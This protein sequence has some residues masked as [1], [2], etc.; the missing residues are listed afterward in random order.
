LPNSLKTRWTGSGLPIFGLMVLLLVLLAACAPAPAPTEVLQ[1][2]PTSPAAEATSQP[3]SPTLPPAPTA[4]P[5]TETLPAEA[6]ETPIVEA[7]ETVLRL[8]LIGDYGLAGEPAAQVAALVK[9]WQPD[10]ILT[11]GDNNYPVGAAET[12]DENIG[13]YYHE[14]IGSYQGA[15][16]AG[17][18]QNRFY[19]ALGNHDLDTD[20][21]QPYYDYFTLPGNERY[22]DLE[23]GP[24]QFFI[25][26]SDSREPDG[27]G[28]SSTQAAWLQTGLFASPAPWKLVISHLPPYSSG[29]H[30]S[31]D[32]IQWPFA[33]WGASAVLSGHDHV[34]ERLEV[35]GIPYFINGLGGGA[36][37]AF[38]EI[39]PES[40]VRYRAGYGAMLVEADRQ[41]ILFRFITVAGE[42]ID[43]FS[44]GSPQFQALQVLPPA[45]PPQN[46]ASLPDPSAYTWQTFASGLASPVGI[47]TVP[48]DAQRLFVL[49]QAGV[50]RVVQGGAV[51]PQAFIDLR[52]RV[53]ANASEQGLLG[54]AFH[55]NFQEN[56]QFFINYTDAS[57]AT[58][59]SRFQASADLASGDPGSEVRLLRVP[60]PYRNHNGGHIAFGPD[61]YLY[62]GMGDGGSAGDPEGNAQN[63]FT[64]LGKVLR[65]DVDGG[66]PYAIPADNPDAAGSQ[67][68]PEIY[69]SGARN[70]WKFDFDPANG[71]LYI[72]DVGQNQWEEVSY[73]PA[74]TVGAN[75][76]WDYREGPMDFEGSPPPGLA[77]VDPAAWYDHSLGCSVSG[78]A[79]YR[80]ADLPDFQG[81]YLYG[82]YCSGRVWGLLREAGG[83]WQNAGLFQ[84]PA[85]ITAIG[86]SPT[87][88]LLLVDHGGSILQLVQP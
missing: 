88:E 13:Q 70:P 1:P 55:P 9:S 47:A 52:D 85:R 22:Y 17:A 24:V 7:S 51:Q 79:V 58:I 34:Y 81:V 54:L 10:Y 77:L 62:I 30:G 16:G 31:I 12:I 26:N 3:A 33:E 37:Y 56:G 57:G 39:L 46:A 32:W 82:D 29:T 25:L 21:G 71:D 44:L 59:V 45:A 72:A 86:R 66:E 69:L 50:V 27:V 48:G 73:L 42:E 35:G 5:A 2:P 64:L 15:Y 18:V 63:P 43:R 53:G 65:L 8:A 67:G 14:Y 11:L 74:G 23:L 28:L 83:G 84:V 60:Q 4:G 75:L 41:G 6:P 40:Q 36:R 20:L 19:P 76:G 68:L 49:E 61:G 87:G 78:G 38:E 80:G